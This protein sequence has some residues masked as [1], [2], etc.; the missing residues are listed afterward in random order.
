MQIIN[1]FLVFHWNVWTVFVIQV[2]LN[3]NEGLRWTRGE[4][5]CNL[6]LDTETYV[7]LDLE[8]INL[9]S[10]WEKEMSL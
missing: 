10:A 9:V 2:V 7:V 6:S 3:E 8:M 1:H 4:Q 5:D